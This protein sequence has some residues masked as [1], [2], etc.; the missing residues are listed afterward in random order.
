[1][2]LARTLTPY[3]GFA[4]FR[5]EGS[6]AVVPILSLGGSPVFRVNSRI[7]LGQGKELF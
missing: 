6:W 7:G 4:R 3:A 5:F 2:A 1:M